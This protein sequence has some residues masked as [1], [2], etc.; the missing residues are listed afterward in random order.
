MWRTTTFSIAVNKRVKISI[1][2]P[3]VEDDIVIAD[4]I[5]EK[6]KISIHVPRVEDDFSFKE[7]SSVF[8]ISI[9]VP[10]VEDDPAS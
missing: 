8:F 1:H 9:H 10:R 4:F 6:G 3:R 5:T 7:M 2:V